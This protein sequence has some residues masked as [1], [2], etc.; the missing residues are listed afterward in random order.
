VGLEPSERAARIAA[1]LVRVVERAVAEV[2]LSLPQYRALAL[3]DDGSRCPSAV[4]GYLALT[5]PSVTAVMDGLVGRGLVERQGDAADRRRVQHRLT[6]EGRR[7]LAA[8]DRAAG[9]RLRQLAADPALVAGL[10]AWGGALDRLE[11]RTGER[12]PARR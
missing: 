4:A 7:L 6:G 11:A 12:E 5:R 9:Q 3:L 1:R 8:A 2:G 10:V